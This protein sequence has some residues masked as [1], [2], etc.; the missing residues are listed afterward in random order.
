MTVALSLTAV[1]TPSVPTGRG[2]IGLR[3][4]TE[5]RILILLVLVLLFLHVCACVS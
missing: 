3:S 1:D 4:V 5:I 2:H